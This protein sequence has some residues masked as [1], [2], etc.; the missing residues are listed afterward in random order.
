LVDRY[1]IDG[2]VTASEPGWVVQPEALAHLGLDDLPRPDAG[3]TPGQLAVGSLGYIKFWGRVCSLHA[4]LLWCKNHSINLAEENP[5]LYSSLLTIYCYH[6]PQDTRADEA[7]L[8]LVR[9]TQGSIRRGP[10]TIGIVLMMFNLNLTQNGAYVDFIRKWNKKAGCQGVVGKRATAMKFI[11][12]LSPHDVIHAIFKH[13]EKMTAG[14]GVWT[15]DNIASKKLFPGFSFGAGR[16]KTWPLRLKVTP[17]S[18]ELMV[19]H[20][21]H[22]H[23]TTPAK[24]RKRPDL[25]HMV[26]VAE[27][28]A[29]LY[30][31]GQEAM[32][33]VPVKESDIK[34]LGSPN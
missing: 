5:L 1:L 10:T 11:M 19:M 8:N 25:Q 12:E 6:V 23:E 34:N 18:M 3:W 17:E 2:F 15:D 28:A 27:I 13:T 31:L 4:L 16:S 32:T 30:A 33:V 26:A 24:M 9:S 29:A 20:A 7:L 21:Q 22:A 14:A